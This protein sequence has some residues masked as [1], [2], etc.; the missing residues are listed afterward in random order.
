MRKTFEHGFTLMEILLVISLVGIL[1]VASLY[2][3]S[4]WKT[5]AQV[6]V[7]NEAFY[8]VYQVMSISCTLSPS[9]GYTEAVIANRL[10][11][12]ETQVSQALP[13]LNGGNYS[14]TA[15]VNCDISSIRAATLTTPALADG[16]TRVCTGNSAEINPATPCL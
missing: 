1:M 11:Q 9:T 6:S 7:A 8:K 10:E 16:T 13:L 5:T 4:T 12:G 14:F 15:P 2:S 3:F